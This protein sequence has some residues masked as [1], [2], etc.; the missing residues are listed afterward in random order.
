MSFLVDETLYG[1]LLCLFCPINIKA[2]A[3]RS[4]LLPDL[5][6]F[7]TVELEAR[8]RVIQ[9]QTPMTKFLRLAFF[10]LSLIALSSA[11]TFAQFGGGGGGFGGG[12]GG[13]GG[14]GGGFGGG[15]G[16][17]GNQ[18]SGVIVDANGVLSTQV[19]TDPNGVLTRQR[20]AEA[21]NRLE[22]D[23]AKPSKLRKV[24][25][26]KLEQAIKERIEAGGGPSDAMLHLAGLTRIDYV[27]CYPE[28]GDIVLAGP[29][30]PWAVAPSGRVQGIET[31]RPV[32]ELQDLVAAL[33][34]FPPGKS[35]Q[36]PL[37]YCSIDPTAEGLSRMQ[38]FLM[39]FGRQ[40]TPGDTQFIVNELRERLGLQVV[41][42]GGVPADTHFAQVLV[43]ADYRM[44]LIGIGLEKAAGPIEELRRTSQSSN[45]QP[46]CHAALVLCARLR[47][48]EGQ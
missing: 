47:A 43:E 38:Q 33:R 4:S 18:G 9:L 36:G 26:T 48:F 11:T 23:L 16:G 1:F 21:M 44:K 5:G 15:G 29:A 32:I 22:G 34:S 42:V 31:G 40:A 14:G 17:G 8:M 39:Q 41:T 6:C 10:S 37:I 7:P 13:F 12:G 25:I 3:N 45:D 30:E 27:F 28:T 24:S 20:V 2:W 35:G 46:E 19:V